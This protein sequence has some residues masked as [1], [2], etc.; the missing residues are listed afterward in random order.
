MLRN[1]EIKRKNGARSVFVLVILFV[2]LLA[3]A[4]GVSFAK[5]LLSS[6]GG[7]NALVST[8][9]IYLNGGVSYNLAIYCGQ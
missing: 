6:S 1:E 5:N 9:I 7:Y 2:I 4:S 3:A 8:F